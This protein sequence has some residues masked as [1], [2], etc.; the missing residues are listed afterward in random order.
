MISMFRIGHQKNFFSLFLNQNYTRA[1]SKST[2]KVLSETELLTSEKFRIVRKEVQLA[3]Q[4]QFSKEVVVH[5]GATV[6][7]PFL[8]DGRIILIRNY[9]FAIGKYLLE[10]CAGTLDPN[11]E[12][13]TCAARELEEETG[14]RADT[15][16]PFKPIPYFYSAP[17]FCTEKL[18]VF[19]A[20]GLTHVGQNLTETEEI[21]VIPKE[22]SEVKS[23]LLNGEFEDVKTIAILSAYFISKE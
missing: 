8:S 20:R 22:E 12:P 2:A 10:L 14:Y 4:H 13:H 23:M 19:V 18:H 6:I 1:M 16:T 5:P 7:L 11:E 17:G 9:R 3:N 15:I 21:D